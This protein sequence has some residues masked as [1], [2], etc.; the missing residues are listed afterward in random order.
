MQSLPSAA[1][2]ASSISDGRF[3]QLG[4]PLLQALRRF[5]VGAAAVTGSVASLNRAIA[6]AKELQGVLE[7][8]LLLE[9]HLA[10]RGRRPGTYVS[11]WH[12]RRRCYKANAR[13]KSLRQSLEQ[14][15]AKNRPPHRVALG[16]DGWAGGPNHKHSEC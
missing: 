1:P 14:F 12:W 6:C 15:K 16:G 2:A 13:C 5:L 10:V 11:N 3:A 8:D 7:E 9:T 4:Q